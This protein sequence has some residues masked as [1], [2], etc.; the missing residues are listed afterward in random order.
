MIDACTGVVI[1]QLHPYP[2]SHVSASSKEKKKTKRQSSTAAKL[3]S[4]IFACGQE[5]LVTVILV[6]NDVSI[7]KIANIKTDHFFFSLLHLKIE[8][9]QSIATMLMNHQTVLWPTDRQ[10]TNHHNAAVR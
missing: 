7:A 6:T 4:T 2:S 5:L 9:R 10:P 1:I 3:Q 8:K